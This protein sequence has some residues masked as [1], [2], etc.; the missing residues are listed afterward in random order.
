MQFF[1]YIF[2]DASL[3]EFVIVGNSKNIVQPTLR[4]NIL[5]CISQ[6]IFYYF[7]KL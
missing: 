6:N 3:D 4:G 2:N 5:L 7:V 1:Y